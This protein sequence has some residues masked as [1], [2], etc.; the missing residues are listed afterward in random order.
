M[1]SSGTG[2]I[3]MLA[4]LLRKQAG[5]KTTPHN[6]RPGFGRGMSGQR[7][8]QPFKGRNPRAGENKEQE[9]LKSPI[10]QA[11]LKK[12]TARTPITDSLRGAR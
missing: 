3:S 11:F 5:Q 6:A 12:Q 1:A 7:G 2:Q 10:M 4:D 9:T 8:A